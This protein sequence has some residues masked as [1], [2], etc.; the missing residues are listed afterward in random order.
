MRSGVRQLHEVRGEAAGPVGSAVRNQRAVDA[1]SQPSFSLRSA[2]AP[3]HWM[4]PLT[5]CLFSV[6]P[7][8]THIDA[9]AVV[10]PW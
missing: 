4:M 8:R 9:S 2:R 1:E 10:F 6:K 5:C 3:A 7:F